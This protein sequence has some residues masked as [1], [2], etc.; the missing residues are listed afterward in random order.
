MCKLY[1][2]PLILCSTCIYLSSDSL[3]KLQAFA[4]KIPSSV[5]HS[6][7]N[8]KQLN[9]YSRVLAKSSRVHIHCPRVEVL[10]SLVRM[11]ELRVARVREHCEL[12][13]YMRTYG[14]RM[15][16]HTYSLS[17]ACTRMVLA[18]MRAHSYCTH[19]YCIDLSRALAPP[20]RVKPKR[21][22]SCL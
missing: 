11:R 15:R 20:S 9:I 2:L 13:Y 1:L 6:I 5:D 19:K 22:L 3:P 21:V 4:L 8:H 7:A 10:H 17:R 18:L 12:K 16:T 14:P